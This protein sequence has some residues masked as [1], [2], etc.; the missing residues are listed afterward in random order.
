MN[1]FSY[2]APIQLH[3]PQNHIDA[4]FAL[5]VGTSE[6]AQCGYPSAKLRS[7][8]WGQKAKRRKTTG[9]GRMRYLK[10]VSRRFKN[11]FRYASFPTSYICSF[12]D[13]CISIGR[14]PPPPSAPR[15]LP[16]RHK[17]NLDLTS[18]RL[19]LLLPVVNFTLLFCIISMYM[20]QV[21][22]PSRHPDL[23]T[24]TRRPCSA[25]PIS[26]NT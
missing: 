8:E 20:P 7:Y 2:L 24:Q 14:T 11:G 16:L 1:K 13:V 26:Q 3:P 17:W 19:S 21:F 25:V 22:F 15:R 12:S 6:C 4:L 23:Y 10:T 9:T 5:F 18:S